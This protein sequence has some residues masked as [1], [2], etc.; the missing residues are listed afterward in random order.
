MKLER[1]DSLRPDIFKGKLLLYPNSSI[2]ILD[3]NVSIFYLEV[4]PLVLLPIK[5]KNEN[6][7][8]DIDEIGRITGRVGKKTFFFVSNRHLILNNPK[9]N[10]FW[11]FTEKNYLPIQEKIETEEEF[12]TQSIISQQM[13]VDGYSN[14]TG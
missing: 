9:I 6:Q 11:I 3:I 2:K 4:K 5:V 7:E 10:S 13:N 1:C 8:L 12:K 14:Q